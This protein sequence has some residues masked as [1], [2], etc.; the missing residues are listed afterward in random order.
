MRTRRILVA[1]GAA[2]GLAGAIAAARV[3]Q[4]LLFGVTPLDGLTMA[5]VVAL[6]ATV[7]F[8]AVGWPAWRAAHI[9]PAT[10]LRVE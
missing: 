7:A 9:D 4:G 10:A 8:V 2:L 1:L 5:G 6:V 3:L